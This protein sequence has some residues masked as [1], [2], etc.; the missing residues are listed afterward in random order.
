MSTN[1]TI[2]MLNENGTVEQIYC[3][4][5]GYLDYV[6]KILVEEYNTTENIKELIAL[7]SI[8]ELHGD[9][10]KVVAYHRDRGDKL[11]ISV[12]KSMHDYLENSMCMEYNYIFVD[13]EWYY[14]NGCPDLSAPGKAGFTKVE[15]ELQKGGD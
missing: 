9:I 2:A 7:G 13:E 8:S 4:W 3:H 6:G 14:C 15:P 12:Y 1:S 5:D 11:E 10:D